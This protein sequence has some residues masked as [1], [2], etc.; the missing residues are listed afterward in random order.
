[1]WKVS[2]WTLI[3]LLNVISLR[4]D[5]RL[6]T[7]QRQRLIERVQKRE[8]IKIQKMIENPYL[9]FGELLR[10]ITLRDDGRLN[11][12]QIKDLIGLVRQR[13]SVS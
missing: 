11:A 2:I 12:Q 10:E 6:T 8:E 7:S 3:S 4:A 5:G 13:I 1:M 9:E